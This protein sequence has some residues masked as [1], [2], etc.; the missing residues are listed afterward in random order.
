MGGVTTF[1]SRSGE[2]ATEVGCVT[3]DVCGWWRCGRLLCPIVLR[4]HRRCLQCFAG[5][6]IGK[7]DAATLP[8]PLASTNR[9]DN[10]GDNIVRSSEMY[11]VTIHANACGKTRISYRVGEHLPM[12]G[13][14]RLLLDSLGMNRTRMLTNF[15][16]TILVWHPQ[17]VGRVSVSGSKDV[18]VAIKM[19][20]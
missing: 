13:T 17:R 2:R 1:T 15:E 7:C 14:L 9:N 20:P 11:L 4:C 10:E 3:C 19:P 12:E 5:V 18:F 16:D 8:L 6:M